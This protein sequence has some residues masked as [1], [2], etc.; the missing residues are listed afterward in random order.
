[1][2]TLK[3]Q[4][5]QMQDLVINYYKVLC[6]LCKRPRVGLRTKSDNG[7]SSLWDVLFVMTNPQRTITPL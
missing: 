2:I 7:I 1:M 5:D 4:K 3:I 6:K